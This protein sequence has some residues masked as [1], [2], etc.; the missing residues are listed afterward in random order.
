MDKVGRSMGLPFPAGREVDELA[1]KYNPEIH[2]NIPKF[3]LVLPAGSLD[4]SFSGLKSAAIREITL[5]K[6]QET[7]LTEN[8]RIEIAYGY[9]SIV[10][11]ILAERVKQATEIHKVKT[12][13]LVGGVSANSALRTKVEDF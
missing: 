4:F 10:T 8:D 3:P 9:Q 7:E 1:K 2:T 13:C 11:D 12:I 6:E 5:R